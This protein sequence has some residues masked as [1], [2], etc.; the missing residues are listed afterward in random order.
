MDEVEYSNLI[1]TVPTIDSPDIFGLPLNANHIVS[2]QKAKELVQRL[3]R[4]SVVN[5]LNDVS[6]VDG[7]SQIRQTQRKRLGPLIKFWKAGISQRSDAL[8]DS[9]KSQ[10]DPMVNAVALE[11]ERVTAFI[12]G[13][14]ECIEEIEKGLF[15]NGSLSENTNSDITELISGVVPWSWNRR[16]N[17]GHGPTNPK[18]FLAE[19]VSREKVLER[20]SKAL[21]DGT[22]WTSSMRIGCSFYPKTLL[23]AFKQY[24][25]HQQRT[26]MDALELKCAWDSGAAAALPMPVLT[27]DGLFVEGALF[28]GRTVREV[29]SEDSAL[30]KAPVC[31]LY[32]DDTS[33]STKHGG[34]SAVDCPVFYSLDRSYK[35]LDV[36]LAV[37]CPAKWRLSGLALIMTNVY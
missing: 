22:F 9:G 30:S 10:S 5:V 13:I 36:R 20:W 16:W 18:V 25:A 27:V 1:Q 7:P 19:L 35:V 28:D 12:R 29:H 23:N 6:S 26:T 14:N 11:R 2:L 34:D 24:T 33:R 32:Y 3:Q 37:E 21:D 17:G 31:F 15:G 8:A 4:L